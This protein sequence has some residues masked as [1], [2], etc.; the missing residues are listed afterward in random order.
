[1]SDAETTAPDVDRG[2]RGS[3][4]PGCLILC[5]ILIVFGGLIVLYTVV[6]SYQNRTIG[7]FTQDQPVSLEIPAADAAAVAA[8]TDKL[9][10]IG[11]AVKEGRS[12]RV[13]FSAA[14]LN[15]LI[16]NLEAAKDFRGNTRIDGIDASGIRAKMALP[17]R[18]GIF[19]K[20]VRYLNATFTLQPEL[21][22]RTVAF[23][24]LA[25]VPDVGEMPP[26]FVKNY[27]IL[28]LFRLD[29]ENPGIEEHI[30]GI[31]AVYTE[32][33]QLVVE[34]KVGQ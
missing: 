2:Y 7:T 27:E 14:D 16:A 25:I 19:E 3:P 11:A 6:G 5:T 18:K 28:D 15:L 12:E 13:L 1:M 17:V 8:A 23:R 32:G 21:R 30:K 4:I 10:K 24:V 33:D 26:G 20:G 31:D 34:T 29:P 9:A 22:A